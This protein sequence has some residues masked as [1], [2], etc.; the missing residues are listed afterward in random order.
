[1]LYCITVIFNVILQRTMLGQPSSHPVIMAC[2]VVVMGFVVGSIGEVHFS[3]MGK[4]SVIH[5]YNHTYT[6]I[7]YTFN[8]SY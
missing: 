1:M 3:L 4:D 8:I 5:L 6:Y 2:I 7:I